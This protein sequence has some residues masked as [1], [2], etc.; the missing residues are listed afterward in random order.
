VEAG[1]RLFIATTAVHFDERY[2]P[3]PDRF[4]IDRYQ[5]PRNEHKTPGV[6]APYGL[7]TH[8]CLGAGLA[9]A[10]IM[11]TI[12]TMLRF[13]K[14]QMTP[15]DYTLKVRPLPTNAPAN[16]FRLKRVG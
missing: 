8:A 13:G 5:A 1:G 11:M 14:F 7:G 4:D 16:N 6:F 12:A 2:Y 10:Q 3:D 15:A 9:E